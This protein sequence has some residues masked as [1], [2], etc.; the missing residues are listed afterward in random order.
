[1]IK[2]IFLI[3]NHQ[4]KIFP[5]GGMKSALKNGAEFPG[6]SWLELGCGNWGPPKEPEQAVSKQA[7][8]AGGMMW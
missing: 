4:F 3:L 8:V 1:M 2:W 7:V 6:I 5:T